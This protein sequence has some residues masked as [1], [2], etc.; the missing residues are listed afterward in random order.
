MLFKASP[1]NVFTLTDYVMIMCNVLKSAVLL[2]LMYQSV[3]PREQRS[4]SYQRVH[5][6]NV[7]SPLKV[8]VGQEVDNLAN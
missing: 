4:V 7:T 1:M 8:D 3:P 6:D 5:E 2:S